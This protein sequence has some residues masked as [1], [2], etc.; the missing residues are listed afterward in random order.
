MGLIRSEVLLP[1]GR[2]PEDSIKTPKGWIV[3]NEPEGLGVII[4]FF[5]KTVNFSY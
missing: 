3:P 1:K 2:R 4:T 5:Y